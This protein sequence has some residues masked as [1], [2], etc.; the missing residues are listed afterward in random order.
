MVLP[1]PFALNF[2]FA[3]H[4]F[5]SG[6]FTSLWISRRGSHPASALT[7]AFGFMF[8][9]AT[10]LHLVPGHL[11]NL[12]TMAW[13]PLVFLAVDGCLARVEK[14][15]ILLGIKPFAPFHANPFGA[16]PILL[17]HPFHHEPLPAFKPS[18]SSWKKNPFGVLGG[19]GGW[20]R[21]AHGGP[22]FGRMG[23]RGGKRENPFFIHGF[24]QHSDR[25]RPKGFGAS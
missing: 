8:G 6:W 4:V 15:W 22:A 17:L 19:H 5:L 14:K 2:D 13:I 7:I 3:R 11:P 12:N 10:F 1:L 25:S 21:G 20:G 24:P 18:Q 9:G 16:R 23:S